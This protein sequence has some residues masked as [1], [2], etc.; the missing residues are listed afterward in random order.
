MPRYK[1]L[2]EYDGAPFAGWQYQENSPSVQRTIMEA[3][4][5]FSGEKV[6]IQGAGKSSNKIT[7]APTGASVAQ[8]WSR[9]ASRLIFQW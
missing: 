4:E 6:M 1:I 2:I 7:S 9:C 5:A 8:A 3:I